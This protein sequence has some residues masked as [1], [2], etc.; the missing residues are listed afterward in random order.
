MRFENVTKQ[1][2]YIFASFYFTS[3]SALSWDTIIIKLTGVKIE[4]ISDTLMDLYIK[5]GMTGGINY[6]SHNVYVNDYCEN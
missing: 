3:A 2:Y 4:L 6:I 1:N 5:K